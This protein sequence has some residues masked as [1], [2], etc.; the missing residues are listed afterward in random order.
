M[1]RIAF[2]L[3][4][5]FICYGFILGQEKAFPK[6]EE[7]KYE[8]S[9]VIQCE[10]DKSDL[11]SRAQKWILNKFGDYKD[12]VVYESEDEGRIT[13]KPEVEI[14]NLGIDMGTLVSFFEH[15]QFLLTI[16]C[17]DGKYR[18][19]INDIIFKKYRHGS[20]IGLV[21]DYDYSPD[22]HLKEIQNYEKRIA[23]TNPKKKKEIEEYNNSIII[24]QK[25]FDKE[26]DYFDQL[27]SSLKK[28]MINNDD[29]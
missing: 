5:L 12:I 13:V 23:E 8:F 25:R 4:F 10:F 1:R 11:F 27:I 24:E 2:S 14:Q 22:Y 26:Y 28:G 17:K 15:G 20:L 19:R 9:E 6:N 16:D 3:S 21:H 7:G 29:F 18:Y